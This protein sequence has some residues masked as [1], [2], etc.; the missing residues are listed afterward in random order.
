MMEWK[1]TE[2]KIEKHLMDHEGRPQEISAT[3]KW[4]N[5]RIIGVPVEEERKLETLYLSKS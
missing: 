2:E 4:N 3:I 5:I 1:E